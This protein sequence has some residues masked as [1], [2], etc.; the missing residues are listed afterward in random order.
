MNKTKRISFYGGPGSSKS[1]TAAWLFS[2]LKIKNIPIELSMEY[3][4]RWAYLQRQVK[5]FDQIYLFAKQ[6]QTESVYLEAGKN[7][8]TDSPPLLAAIYADHY[9][10]DLAMG[11]H[12]RALEEEYTNTYPSLN[13]FLDRKERPYDPTGRYQS[14]EEAKRIDEAIRKGLDN[15]TVV[16]YSDRDKIL[17]LAEDF[18]N[19]D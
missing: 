14:Y 7:I 16:D 2:E 4:K 9:Y 13:I 5:K 10:P 12:I 1:T 17:K 6:I 3:V 18:L 8:V 11:K 15:L 19:G